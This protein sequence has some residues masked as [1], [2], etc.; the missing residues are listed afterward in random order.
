MQK[1]S[2]RA[3]AIA[4]ACGLTGCAGANAPG[5]GVSMSRL[6]EL[7]NEARA[8]S[9]WNLKPLSADRQLMDYARAWAETMA[10]RGRMTHSSM[11][12]V[13]A[14]GYS[15]AGENIAWGQST[16]ADV[17]SAWLWSPG[18]RANI[19]GSR[20]SRIGCGAAEAKG[21][22]YWCVVFGRPKK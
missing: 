7:H 10:G 12:D 8:K 18:H 16:E 20:Y 11:R 14:L 19:M 9:W 22:L 17:M 6:V 3:A 15:P 13:M 4:V 5:G 2:R 21:R 1:L